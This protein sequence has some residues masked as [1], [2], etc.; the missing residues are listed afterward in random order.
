MLKIFKDFFKMKNILLLTGLLATGIGAYGGMPQPPKLF[1]EITQK[2]EI[3]QWFLVYVLIWQGSGGYD[4]KI[5][6][7]GT[8]VL[9]ILYKIVIMLEETEYIKKNFLQKIIKKTD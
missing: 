7:Y 3:L 9:F 6:L 5:S 4:E 2:Y 8:I 1:I